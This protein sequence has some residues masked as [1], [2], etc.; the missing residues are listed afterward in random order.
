MFLVLVFYFNSAGW[1]HHN[2]NSKVMLYPKKGF[3]LYFDSL[4]LP[5]TPLRARRSGQDAQYRSLR[6]SAPPRDK[7][8]QTV[9][10]RAAEVAERIKT[11]KPLAVDLPQKDLGFLCVTL[12][13]CVRPL[14]KIHI[15]IQEEDH[16]GV[17][18]AETCTER[19][20]LSGLP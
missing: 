9:S 14:V 12:R 11:K 18:T 3:S 2:H 19:P 4:R 17:V 13:L 6:I 7:A 16:K 1:L 10:R 20:V 15:M 5:S 8:F